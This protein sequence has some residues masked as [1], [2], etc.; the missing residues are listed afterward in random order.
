[1]DAGRLRPELLALIRRFFRKH[2]LQEEAEDI[3]QEV[4][5]RLWQAEHDGASVRDRRAWAVTVA[6]HLCVSRYRE[7]RSRSRVSVEKEDLRSAGSADAPLASTEARQAA[8]AA[9]E[10]LSPGTRRLLQMRSAGM[11]LDEI[12]AASGRPKTSVKT[13]LSAARKQI[14]EYFNKTI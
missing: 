11:S 1:M 5:L 2:I 9:L 8:A 4:L 12:A 10:G 3:V 6:R 14:V 13:S 7:E